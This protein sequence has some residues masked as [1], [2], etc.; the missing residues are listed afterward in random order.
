MPITGQR[1]ARALQGFGEGFAG[2]GQTF[3]QNLDD[4]RKQALLDDAFTVQKQLTAGDV[5][6]ARGTLLDRL[7]AIEQL[8]GNPADTDSLLLKITRG[9]TAGALADVTTVVDFG[10]KSGRLKPPSGF[11]L[12]PGQSRFEGGKEVASLPAN[13]TTTPADQQSFEAL[14]KGFSSE[15]KIT[16]RRIKAGLDPR[17]VG[18][19]AITITDQQIA[20]VV[21]RTN[22]TLAKG[23][24]SGKLIAQLKLKP[25]VQAAVTTAVAGATA[26]ADQAILEGTNQASFDVYDVG[27]RAL[28]SGMDNALTGPFVGLLPAVTANAQISDAA[29]AAMLP[30]M[31]QLFR[32]SGEGIFTDRDQE[33]L[34]GMLPNR[35]MLPE[36]RASAMF[37]VDAIV[38]AKLGV[39]RPEQAQPGTGAGD[40]LQFDEQG[41]LVQ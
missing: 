9:D 18:S 33:L 22:Q 39:G 26:L 32:S 8:G 37:N 35:K 41:N 38:R 31:K 12:S 29:L 21:A 7:Q 15:D 40:V 20:E 25:K 28:V 34:E 11:T 6:G 4:N 3:L 36:A 13:A 27:M 2:R 14:I 23:T 16:A 30:V 10:V 17:A 1:V 24:E 5:S 19:A